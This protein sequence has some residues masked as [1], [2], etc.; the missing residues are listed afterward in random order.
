MTKFLLLAALSVVFVASS[1][2]SGELSRREAAR[3]AAERAEAATKSGPA[4][5]AQSAPSAPPAVD[6]A[7]V[8][9][10]KDADLHAAAD[11]VG[12]RY[13]LREIDGKELPEDTDAFVEWRTTSSMG[14]KFCNVFRATG[15][16]ENSIVKAEELPAM[17]KMACNDEAMGK[18]EERFFPALKLGLSFLAIGDSLELRRDD[19]VLRFELAKEK[20]EAA[21]DN[22]APAE[23]AEAQEET[24]DD[25]DGVKAE[26]ADDV[27]EKPDTAEADAEAPIVSE[28]LVSEEL[29]LDRKFFLSK[30]DGEEFAVAAGVQP[31]IEFGEGMRVGGSACNVFT[32]LGALVDDK[33]IV[34]NAVATRKMCI[35]PKLSA[36]E[37]DFHT[38]LREGAV[39]TLDGHLLTLSGGDKVLEFVEEGEEK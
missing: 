12:K 30:V 33:L 19:L 1:G 14:G 6:A 3:L 31:F 37:R 13:L 21:A 32:G 26:D 10:V 7:N 25:E 5:P 35:D 17:T 39:L 11:L 23:A 4:A 16:F 22:E 20:P 18:L 9:I 38:M 2:L 28:L 8:T 34:A 27:A 36:F 15:T 29:L 24:A